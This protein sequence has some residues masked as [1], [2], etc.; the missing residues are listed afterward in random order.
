VSEDSEKS[1]SPQEEWRKEHERCVAESRLVLRP[2][3]ASMLAG[4]ALGTRFRANEAITDG[5]SAPKEG[6]EGSKN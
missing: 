3:V 4:R 6:G 5:Q 2:V 1:Q